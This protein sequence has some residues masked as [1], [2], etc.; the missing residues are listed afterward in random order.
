[1]TFKEEYQKNMKWGIFA[2][3]IMLIA[4]AGFYFHAV[5][6]DFNRECDFCKT[7]DCMDNNFMC[8]D[9]GIY[10]FKFFTLIGMGVF[11]AM[12]IIIPTTDENLEMKP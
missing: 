12:F 7:A 10:Y 9:F 3:G 1:M 8:G 2:I 11:G 4:M 5:Q 6:M